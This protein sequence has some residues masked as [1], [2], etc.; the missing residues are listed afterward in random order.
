MT[1]TV[2]ERVLT[3]SGEKAK[4]E[5]DSEFYSYQERRSG[6]FSRS[7][8]LPK[9]ANSGAVSAKMESGELTITIGKEKKEEPKKIDISVN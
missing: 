8:T 9:S 6:K 5:I 2:E 7:F 4:R 1:I 3:I